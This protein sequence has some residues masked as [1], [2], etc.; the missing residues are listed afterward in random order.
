VAACIVSLDKEK[1][2]EL[3]GQC[4]IVKEVDEWETLITHY[5]NRKMILIADP[6]L[7][8]FS[9]EGSELFQKALQAGHRVI[10]AI[11]RGGVLNVSL[12]VPLPSPSVHELQRALVEAGYNSERARKLAQK[13]GGNLSTLVKLLQGVSLTP[14]WAQES[15]AT[16]LALAMLIGAWD[17]KN[18]ADRKIVEE[19]TGESYDKWGG[20]LREIVLR[21]DVPLIYRDGKWKFISRYEAWYALGPR[22]FD[23]HLV[24]LKKVA[25]KVLQEK[26]PQFDLP[27]VKRY[28]ASIYGKVFSYSNRLRQ[29]LAETLALLG[30][31]PEALKYCSLGKAE[32]TAVLT[33]R[34]LLA[35][36]D[37]LQW[38]SLNDVLPLLA[39]AAP[40]EF[41]DAVEKALKK[42]PCPFDGIFAQEGESN[43]MTGLLWALE[44][45]AWD[46]D[47]L[48]RS[49]V[50]LGKLAE[51]DPGGQWANRPINSLGTILMPWLPQTC[52]P[53]E[54]RV[55]AVKTLL[56]ESPEI[57]WKVL[58]SLLPQQFSVSTGSY[59]PVW[60]EIIPEDWTE[61]VTVS[62]YLEQV[63][64]YAKLALE[65]ARKNCSKLG[66]LIERFENLP[67]SAQRDLLE[68]L[69]S[70]EIYAL[71]ESEKAYLWNK[72]IDL[73]TK[74]RKFA[75][76]RWAMPAD[77]VTEVESVA[78]RLA[79]QDPLLQHQRL[80]AEFDFD[81]CEGTEDYKHQWKELE[82]HRQEAVRE[83]KTKGGIQTILNFALSVESPRKVG[84]AFG[85]V[86]E[87]ETDQEILPG[88]LS[89]QNLF[90][91]V[92]GY[93]MGR[94]HG[95]KWE[96][97]DN[98]DTMG[99]TPEQIAKFLCFLPFVPE[100]WERAE[101]LLGNKESLYWTQVNVN[102]FGI[103]ES[104][105]RA[106]AKLI[107]H[108]RPLS[109][110]RCI[111]RMLHDKQPFDTNMAV[112]ALLEVPQSKE[113]PTSMD[114]HEI[115]EIITALQNDPNV[116][117]ED[118]LRI[119]WAYLPLLD[120]YH[121][122]T[123]KTLEQKL[124]G[125]PKFF[126]EFIRIALGSEKE[127]CSKEQKRIA[128]NA[129]RL[130]FNWRTPPGSQEDGT[131]DAGA[132]QAWIEKVK[133][134]CEET[135]HLKIA[136]EIV[137]QVLTHAPADPDGLWIHRAVAEALNS[138]N[139]DHMRIGFRTALINSRGVHW[140]DPSGKQERELAE[141]YRR[142]AE[143]VESCGYHRL[144]DIMRSLAETYEHEADRIIAEKREN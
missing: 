131:F 83:I 85:A 132:F 92:S 9:E 122:A 52:A 33:V 6:R 17:E 102:P 47:Y 57:G 135:G 43:Y 81:L 86:A 99:W 30:A 46:P 41:L 100:T 28:A 108:D 90:Q 88:L 36:P 54:K 34:E 60:R 55:V 124:A 14:S 61:K 78:H 114:I 113:K 67:P 16:Y 38:A 89:D 82:K 45:L 26:D 140:V 95:R 42:S 71:P 24:R 40:R 56:R 74:H 118:L 21:P 120:G 103:R 66:D 53:V 76:A 91:F 127:G 134:E 141:R 144:A 94:F 117:T 58:L 49:V 139:A 4:L 18:E 13:S 130:L 128:E 65:A 109:A 15:D 11:P 22:V 12:D 107:E 68:R 39:E 111:S 136:M 31:Q 5:G 3:L 84:L 112:R 62:E 37:W 101:R 7:D 25:V 59:K 125:D 77:K 70:E 98:I 96:W 27:K 23:D 116:K 63:E 138:I 80:F 20:K 105:E 10:T 119:E 75:D 44:T 121:G 93:I 29:G 126:C 79:P 115:S 73:V 48:V 142:M 64:H 2:T 51:R 50:C 1:R 123:P 32:A 143:E 35:E 69:S 133:K 106:V 72:L 110:L 19:L 129:S 87:D 104:P 97:V 8:L 137:G